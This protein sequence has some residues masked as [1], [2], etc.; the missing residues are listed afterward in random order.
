RA[1]KAAWVVLYS[2]IAAKIGSG[3]SNGAAIAGVRVAVAAPARMARRLMRVD[4]A[5]SF[6]CG[7]WAHQ[8]AEPRGFRAIW[9]MVMRAANPVRV[10]RPGPASQ[11]SGRGA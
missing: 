1:R 2:S 6:P 3:P 9:G 5:S 10:A 8:R 7:E 4:M 11:A